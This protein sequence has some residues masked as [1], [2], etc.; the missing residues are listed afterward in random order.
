MNKLS[1]FIDEHQ[2]IRQGME[3]LDKV[4]KE[5]L[6]VLFVIDAEGRLLGTLS[7][8]D[9]RRGLLAGSTMEDDIGGLCNVN[10]KY[11]KDGKF[12]IE[13]VRAFKASN[14]HI[15]PLIDEDRRIIKVF[16]L[17]AKRSILPLSVFISAGGKGTRLKPLTDNCPKPMLKLGDKPI[18]EYNI[19][20]LISFGV[21]NF[22][23]S[24]SY[25]G[26]QIKDYFKN[27]KHKEVNIFYVE[28]D[29][30]LG[31]IGGISLVEEFKSEYILLCNSDLLTT[32]NYEVFFESFIEEEA[33][34]SVCT[35]PYKVIIPYG[36]I[37]TENN[38]IKALSEKPTYTYY[39]NGGIYLFKK[40]VLKNIPYNSFYNTTDLI[41]KLIEEGKKVLSHPLVGYW[42]DIGQMHEYEKAQN[43][44]K[45]LDLI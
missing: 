9:I 7:D 28:E 13:E 8:G 10:C 44:I 38:V 40:E 16:N 35:I 17:T 15:I 23:I 37:E 14:N 4:G 26:E 12:S 30:P 45:N 18:L 43:D 39:S 41:L 2:S 21:V 42:L 29:H 22:Y 6:D 31:T 1:N 11:L 34:L 36:V 20:R 3:L 33:D 5:A 25:L 19:D 27:G 32:I 24:V